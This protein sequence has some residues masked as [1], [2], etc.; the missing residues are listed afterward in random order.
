[1]MAPC[2]VHWRAIDRFHRA[3]FGCS[4]T[5]WRT[6]IS[7]RFAIL[8][9]FSL[10]FPDP[11]YFPLAVL[12]YWQHFAYW[13]LNFVTLSN[14]DIC[15]VDS[16]HFGPIPMNLVSSVVRWR[17]SS[18]SV[19]LTQSTYYSISSFPQIF[20]TFGSLPKPTKRPLVLATEEQWGVF[21]R[22]NKYAFVM[23]CIRTN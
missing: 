20:P 2:P 11:S 4:P 1:M 9:P 17:V 23:T 18:Q 7:S 13:A 5:I 3:S 8:Y 16:R 15:S 19:S 6:G 21:E 10:S 14:S 12:L 22:T